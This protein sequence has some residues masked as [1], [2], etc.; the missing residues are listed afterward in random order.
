[1]CLTPSPRTAPG[2]VLA[3]DAPAPPEVQSGAFVKPI[4][5]DRPGL[6]ST[7]NQ[8]RARRA[9]ALFSLWEK[10][11]EGRMRAGGIKRK[12]RF[13]EEVAEV[14]LQTRV[15]LHAVTIGRAWRWPNGIRLSRTVSPGL[16]ST[17]NNP[18]SRPNLGAQVAI[19]STDLFAKAVH[20]SLYRWTLCR[21][22]HF[23]PATPKP[24]FLAF[25]LA[26]P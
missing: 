23:S 17:I 10:V 2:Q 9:V 3:N 13:T 21:W 15:G 6:A 22:R 20:S 25:F 4:S 26:R 8:Q 11:A 5:I 7:A 18:A 19:P 16:L 12:M 1:M 14:S 24:H